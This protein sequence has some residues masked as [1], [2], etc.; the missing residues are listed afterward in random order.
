MHNIHEFPRNPLHPE[1]LTIGDVHKGTPFVA[2][3]GDEQ[4]LEG[5]FLG[6][7]PYDETDGE[8]TPIPVETPDGEQ[9][10][11]CPYGSGIARHRD[12]KWTPA[13]FVVSAETSL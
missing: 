3:R 4:I 6:S 8:Y 9:A 7:A 12:G 11:L 2:V 1:A 5:T 10:T 13:A